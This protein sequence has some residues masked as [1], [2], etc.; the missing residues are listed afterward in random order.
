[1]NNPDF[2][3]GNMKI[4]YGFLPNHS[5]SLI[6]NIKGLEKFS[7][8]G[9]AIL[10][11]KF[12][13]HMDTGIVFSAL[14]HDNEPLHYPAFQGD[15]LNIMIDQRVRR[16]VSATS[17]PPSKSLTE[18]NKTIT[19]DCNGAARRAKSRARIPNAERKRFRKENNLDLTEKN[20]RQFIARRNTILAFFQSSTG[21]PHGHSTSRSADKTHQSAAKTH[22]THQT[23]HRYSETL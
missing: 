5:L 12:I 6:E 2:K 10:K 11:T 16:K 18:C 14:I 15:I 21:N 22:Q 7:Y 1:M 9:N 3:F 8:Q 4:L 13:A 17:T 23:R 20:W 19:Q